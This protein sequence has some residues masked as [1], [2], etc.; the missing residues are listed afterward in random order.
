MFDKGNSGNYYGIDI[1]KVL[2]CI[3]V[4][5]IHT[6]GGFGPYPYL[7]VAVPMFFCISSFL[8]FQKCDGANDTKRLKR[9]LLRNARL[10]AFGFTVLLLPTLILGGWLQGN[11]F[12]NAVKFIARIFVGSTFAGSWYIPALMICVSIVYW[13]G[14]K[15]PAWIMILVYCIIDI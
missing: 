5:A 7:R 11:I 1:A 13:C 14:R 12:A 8:F 9:F 15:V 4:V 10:Y 3:M 2:F 6:M